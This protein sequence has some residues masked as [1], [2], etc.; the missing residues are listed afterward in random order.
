MCEPTELAV[1]PAHKGFVWLTVRFR[2][3]AAH[4]SRPEVGVDAVRHAAL[5]L[6]ELESHHEA[7]AEGQRHPLLG[8]G[9]FHFGR[10]RGGVAPSVYPDACTVE[11]E[12]RT[13][14]GEGDE[15]I[16]PFVDALNAVQSRH[17]EVKGELRVDLVRPPSD[18]SADHALV[19]DLVDA[20]RAE[21][22]PGQVLGMSAWVDAAFLNE[23]GIPAVCFGP[24]SIEKAHTADEWV[25]VADLETGQR[26]LERFL[27]VGADTE[28]SPVHRGSNG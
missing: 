15:V 7:L 21:G 25:P 5:Y 2:G 1:H 11:I 4:G 18:V 27:G 20:Q 10:I 16:Q 24:G 26:V 3:R 6:A 9:S 14:P 28:P 22:L 12:R 8:P 17:P 19:R 13:L 23:A